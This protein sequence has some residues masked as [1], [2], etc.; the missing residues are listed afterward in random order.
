MTAEVQ[1]TCTPG[2]S[3]SDLGRSTGHTE[4]DFPQLHVNYLKIG[5]KFFLPNR[6]RFIVHNNFSLL[7]DGIWSCSSQSVVK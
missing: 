5:H 7:L 3:M 1:V 2:I 4:Q 6:Y